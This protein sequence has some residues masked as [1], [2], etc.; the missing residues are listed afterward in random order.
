MADDYCGSVTSFGD[1][2]DSWSEEEAEFVPPM[3][4]IQPPPV[5]QLP[6][7]IAMVNGNLGID[8]QFEDTDDE[9]V[10]MVAVMGVSFNATNGEVLAMI[11]GNVEA[12]ANNVAD[13]KELFNDARSIGGGKEKRNNQPTRSS[14]IITAKHYMESRGRIIS[15][16]EPDDII[17]VEGSTSLDPANVAFIAKVE[18]TSFVNESS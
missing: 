2:L 10:E 14:L 6:L 4:V 13:G 18:E 5:D 3:D 12:P 8:K 9:Y 16:S 11:K 7:I 15:F 17:H 1:N